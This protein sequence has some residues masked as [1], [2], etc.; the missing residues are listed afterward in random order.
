MSL[1]A[2]FRDNELAN[3]YRK[4]GLFIR[5]TA[6][7]RRRKKKKGQLIVFGA[8]QWVWSTRAWRNK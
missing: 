1:N 2:Q 6:E 5:R 7:K 3:N 4:C 8:K